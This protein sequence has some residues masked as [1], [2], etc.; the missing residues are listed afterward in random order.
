MK[1]TL[2][3]IVTQNVYA[4]RILLEKITNLP[5]AIQMFLEIFAHK[6]LLCGCSPYFN[7]LFGSRGG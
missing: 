2:L 7:T 6:L 5:T 3:N 4:Q 1:Q